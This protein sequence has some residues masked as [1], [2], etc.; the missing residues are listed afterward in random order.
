[1][2]YLAKHLEAAES[3]EGI[4]QIFAVIA[5]AGGPTMAELR[6]M[7]ISR[8]AELRGAVEDAFATH[9]DIIPDEQVG[10]G[11]L[12]WTVNLTSSVCGHYTLHIRE[13]LGRDLQTPGRTAYQHNRNLLLNL[14][15]VPGDAARLKPGDIDDMP[16][17]EY[18]NVVLHL[19]RI[20]SADYQGF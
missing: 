11:L 7:P 13:P 10:E 15:S 12:A 17:G 18:Q 20:G 8:S 1:M 16:I 19:A 5:A 2:D 6:A 9:G 14:V 3:H 4:D